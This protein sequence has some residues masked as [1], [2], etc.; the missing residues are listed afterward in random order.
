MDTL[1]NALHRTV[2]YA[3]DKVV[4][5]HSPGDHGRTVTGVDVVP[6]YFPLR[7]RLDVF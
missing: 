5:H 3:E 1:D 4:S 7:S 2:A 6:G